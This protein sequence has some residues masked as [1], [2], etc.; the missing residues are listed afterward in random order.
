MWLST[1]LW[2][3]PQPAEMELW[4]RIKFKRSNNSR[5]IRD[6]ANTLGGKDQHKL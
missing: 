1:T 5:R 2:K 4:V 3:I 6:C